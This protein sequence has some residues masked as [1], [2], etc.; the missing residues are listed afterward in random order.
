MN[1][2]R[3]LLVFTWI[4]L[5]L[6]PMGLGLL[7][8]SLFLDDKKLWW[9]FAVP[10]L[11]GVIGA[12][13]LVG[14]VKYRVHGEDNLPAQ[15]DMRRVILCPKHQ[16]TWETFFFPSMTSHPLSYVFKQ[17]LLRI[18]VFGWAMARLR[19]VH[20]DRSKRSEAWNKVAELGQQLMDEGKWIIMFPEGTRTER[21][22]KGD[23]KTG[24]SRLAITT[25]AYIIPIAVTSGRCWPRRSFSF[26]PGTIDV[27]IGEPVYADGREQGELMDEIE[28]WIEAE[29]HRLD[30][31]A[32]Q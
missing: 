18:P 19:M 9:W 17:E 23:Y 12:A 24:A 28:R 3:S 26:I 27:S 15:Q 31:E 5:S 14:G 29:M 2:I 10:W 8:C 32:Y 1:A 21:G 6:I 20:I 16:S 30:A 13:R 7:L 22:S 25:G 11:K 4:V